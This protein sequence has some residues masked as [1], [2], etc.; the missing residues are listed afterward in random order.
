MDQEEMARAEK[1]ARERDAERKR[2]LGQTPFGLF[3]SA[4][5]IVGESPIANWLRGR[6]HEAI[7]RELNDA[8][9]GRDWL[10]FQTCLVERLATLLEASGAHEGS[11]AS[12]AAG[13][14]EAIA[15]LARQARAKRRGAAQ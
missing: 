13:L 3:V 1:A 8:M 12:R 5:E 10:V 7:N 15:E 4:G 11:F 14:G 6:E 9:V 2:L